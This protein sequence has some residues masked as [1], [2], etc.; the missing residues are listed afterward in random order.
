MKRIHIAGLL[1]AVLVFAATASAQNS[2]SQ[3][4]IGGETF[5]RATHAGDHRGG[6]ALVRPQQ[7]AAARIGQ[8]LEIARPAQQQAGAAVLFHQREDER[9][10]RRRIGLDVRMIAPRRAVVLDVNA[11]RVGRLVKAR[12]VRDMTEVPAFEP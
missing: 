3:F 8:C 12:C 10:A 7:R 9:T 4:V 5:Q 6:I 1:C 2:L 11:Q